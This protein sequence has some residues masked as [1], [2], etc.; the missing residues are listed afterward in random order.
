[1]F[2]FSEIGLLTDWSKGRVFMAIC[3]DAE[4]PTDF[5]PAAMA[6]LLKFQTRLA[7]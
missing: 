7:K 4:E 6:K 2:D 5:F 3:P 1:V